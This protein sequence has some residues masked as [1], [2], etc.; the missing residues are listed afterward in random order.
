M[1]CVARGVGNN[2]VGAMLKQKQTDAR[3]NLGKPAPG[4]LN[5]SGFNESRDDGVTVSAG[6]KQVVRISTTF[7]RGHHHAV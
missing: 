4:R 5:Q 2:D 7:T 3:C 6:L 1:G